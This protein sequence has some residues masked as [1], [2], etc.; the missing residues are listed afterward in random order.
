MPHTLSGL[1]PEAQVQMSN[2]G[3]TPAT[4]VRTNL[5]MDLSP[6]KERTEIGW[7]ETEPYFETIVGNGRP[8]FL[9]ARRLI[10]AE[11]YTCIK[12][13]SLFVYVYGR[14]TYKDVFGA[15]H[16]TKVCYVLDMTRPRDP[17][18]VATLLNSLT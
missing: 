18:F 15:A 12:Q 9:L 10:T 1:R 14:V 13:E 3:Q 6:E 17:Q 5:I 8:F 16:E 2:V 4:R 7:P 11:E